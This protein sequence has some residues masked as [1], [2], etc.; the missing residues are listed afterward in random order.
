[1]AKRRENG[2]GSIYRDGSG[3]WRATITTGYDENGKRRRRYLHGRTKS[4]VIGKLAELRA[5][6]VG[7]TVSEPSRVTVREF[8]ERWLEMAASER[9]RPTTRATY[10]SLLRRHVT[11]HLGGVRLTQL[12]PLQL[13]SWQTTLARD[14]VSVFQRRAAQALFKTIL[15]RAVK[16]RIL[17]R[18]PLDA[19]DMPRRPHREIT[20]LEP[21]EVQKLLEATRGDRLEAV[22]VLAVATGARQG[23]L[24][25]LRWSDVDLAAGS[26]TIRRT[27]IEANGELSFGEPK[28]PRSR[29]RVELPAYAVDALRRHLES[30]PAIPHPTAL[31]FTDGTGNPLRKSN[32]TRREWHPLLER[33]GVKP[34]KFHSL[35]HSHVTTLLAAGGNLQA[36]SERV[37]HARSSMTADVYAHV[38]EG[39]QRAL[40][41][42]LDRLHGCE[43][44]GSASAANEGTSEAS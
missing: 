1:M 24:F 18:N 41:D 15:T 9:I 43:E 22:Y 36:V 28:T 27:L 31:V 16:L 4:E 37:G 8:A 6:V 11:P 42:T 23:E 29:R 38:V 20:I 13:Q 10:E 35:R 33:A 14:K 7:G 25:G 39:M 21:D 19:L 32:F 26:L 40:V 34:V 30:Q 2:E 12:S 5:D 17:A 3:R 44:P